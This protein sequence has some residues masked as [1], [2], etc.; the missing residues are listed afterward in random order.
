MQLTAAARGRLISDPTF[1]ALLGTDVGT[2]DVSA[3]PW[4]FQETD[5]TSRPSADIEKSGQAA[6]VLGLRRSS[7]TASRTSMRFTT[8]LVSIWADDSRP[9]DGTWTPDARDR[10]ERVANAV[11]STLNQV[12][13]NGGL[14]GELYV[15]A[16]HLQSD[17]SIL[18]VPTMDGPVM[19][20]MAFDVAFA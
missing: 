17:L 20:Q 11:V 7:M 15:V 4:V 1:V 18:D 8:L 2:D 10:C 12:G 19:G 16:C 13:D 9:P 6:V 3:Q 14:W 5:T